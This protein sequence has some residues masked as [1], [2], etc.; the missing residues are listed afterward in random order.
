MEYTALVLRLAAAF[1]RDS[2]ADL[3][4]DRS[5]GSPGLAERCSAAQKADNG[6]VLKTPYE[7]G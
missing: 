5:D 6:W 4:R 7:W 2:S 3:Y 1:R